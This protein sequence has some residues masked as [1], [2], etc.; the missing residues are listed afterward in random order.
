MRLQHTI[1]C[2]KRSWNR[3][4]RKGPGTGDQILV[5]SQ[6]L[7]RN[8]ARFNLD[9]VYWNH[10]SRKL[11]DQQNNTQS[12]NLINEMLFPKVVHFGKVTLIDAPL[13]C[14]IGN[15]S[16]ESDKHNKFH[17]HLVYEI[18]HIKGKKQSICN[19]TY[20]IGYL[21]KSIGQYE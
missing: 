4:P 9:G 12:E 19:G 3:W 13:S 16:K 15:G 7:W 10:T 21:L 6:C 8:G 17:R 18:R 20:L 2:Q 11:I 1:N 14:N 5:F